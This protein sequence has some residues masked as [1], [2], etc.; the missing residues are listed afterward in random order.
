[1]ATRLPLNALHVFCA[2]V[3]SGGFRPAAQVLCV[4][5]GAVSRQVQALEQHLGQAL[6]E[7]SAG[8]ATLTPAG[9]QLHQRVADKMESI[10]AALDGAQAGERRST[11]R[12]DAGVTLAMHWLIPRLRSFSERHPR[13]QVQVRTSDG[14]IDAAAPVDVFIRREEAELQGLPA[15][16]FMSERSALVA[17]PSLATGRTLRTTRDLRGLARLPRVAARSRPD[18]WPQWCRFHGLDELEP[19]LEFDNT[20]LAIQAAAQGL[21][22]CV[23][24]EIFV[25][26][27]LDSG[28][29][30]CLHAQRVE[31]GSYAFAVGRRRESARVNTFIEWLRGPAAA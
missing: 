6:F 29:L 25:A 13:I 30:C 20:V 1:M 28:A 18:L 23:V 8:T 24:P 19:T 12:V 5:P 31:T 27:M 17:N 22:V 2:V 11:V 3:R 9:R 21:G 16:V 14:A 15:Q 4:T 7:R 26:G 10:G